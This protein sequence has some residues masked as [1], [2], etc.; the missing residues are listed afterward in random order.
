VANVGRTGADS[1][2]EQIKEDAD[3]GITLTALGFGMGNYN[4]VLMEQLASH[5]DG[6]YYYIDTIEEAERLFADG[7]VSL[8]QVVAED[9][10]IQ[11]EFD[12][13]LVVRY[14]LLGYE[15]RA[16]DNEQFRDDDAEEVQQASGEIGAG[17]TVTALYEV[18]IKDEAL[19]AAN[20]AIAVVRVRYRNLESREM[21]E[22]EQRVTVASVDREFANANPRFRFTACVA[23]FAEILKECYWAQEGD[24]TD[25]I[26]VASAAVSDM[27]GTVSD[28]KEFLELVEKAARLQN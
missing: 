20:N 24:L 6:N 21:A 7:A 27:D 14:R 25:V 2:M 28:E 18:R 17:Q 1:I 5:G 4:D 26:E 9:A 16:I 11:V 13:N 23:E 19:L 12:E 8:L 10:R 3:K 15:N 22:T